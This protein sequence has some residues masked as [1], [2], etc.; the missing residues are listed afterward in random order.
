MMH[1]RCRQFLLLMVDFK[2]LNKEEKQVNKGS[3]YQ[4]KIKLKIKTGLTEEG[5]TTIGNATNEGAITRI[6]ILKS[7]P[8][9]HQGG[10]MSFSG[11][12]YHDSQEANHC[13]NNRLVTIEETN[14]A[15]QGTLH[16]HTQ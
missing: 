14:A 11:R 3:T 12:G 2:T 15:I 5:G 16:N 7:K 8:S 4:T 9:G 10:R 13:F 1:T 6:L